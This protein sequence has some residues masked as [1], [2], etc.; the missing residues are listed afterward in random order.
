MFGIHIHRRKEATK[1]IDGESD[2]QHTHTN[3]SHY[4]PSTR[5]F[6]KGMDFPLSP[7]FFHVS[8]MGCPESSA[9]VRK[10]VCAWYIIHHPRDGGG[11]ATIVKSYIYCPVGV[12]LS[13]IN[14]KDRYE[15]EISY[16]NNIVKTTF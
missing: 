1:R 10:V 9:S 16:I 14:F 13:V 4:L 7:L 15:E 5:R 6:A 8:R 12:H 2:V 3:G 11:V